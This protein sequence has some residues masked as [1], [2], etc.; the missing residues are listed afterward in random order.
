MTKSRSASI[1]ESNRWGSPRP[2]TCG[3]CRATGAR[4]T[5]GARSWRSQQIHSDRTADQGQAIPSNRP[6]SR[7]ETLRPLG[8]EIS[9]SLPKPRPGF[10]EDR[11]GRPSFNFAGSTLFGAFFH[12]AGPSLLLHRQRSLQRCRN[13]R[14]KILPL[15]WGQ[16]LGGRQNRRGSHYCR[17]A[18]TSGGY[19][20]GLRWNCGDGRLPGRRERSTRPGNSKKSVLIRTHPSGT[21]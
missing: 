9:P 5:G 16:R 2:D 21:P 19:N 17:R 11:L 7:A 14:T 12:P 20:P 6:R 4:Q 10:G 8:G 18:R 1:V 15:L 3:R 13:L